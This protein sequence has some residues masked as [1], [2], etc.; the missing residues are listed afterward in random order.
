MTNY[1]KT[2][3]LLGALTALLFYIGSFW[4]QTGITMALVF[5]GLMNFV[6]YYYSDKIALSMYGAQPVSRADAPE[7]YRI[8]ENLTAR[9]NMPAPKIYIIPSESP[10]AFATGRNPQ[11]ASVAVTQGLMRILDGTELEGVIAHELGH[12]K[13]R[14]ILIA[15]I[16]ATIAAAVM[17][18]SS[19]A[20]WAAIFGGFGRD[21]ENGASGLEFLF[22][23]ILAPVAAMLIQLAVSR[24]REYGADS[25]G[26]YYAG[27]PYGLARALEKIHKYSQRVPLEA[28]PSTAHLFI[29]QPLVGGDFLK[30]LF[31]THPPIEK[32]IARLLGQAR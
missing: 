28:S 5:A 3:L 15:T 17:W 21:R 9:M 20:R 11:H 19:M 32:R 25:T 31:S 14:D 7:L 23:I 10:N 12:V 2:A 27:N 13:N 18:I 6:S 30:S 24:S 26:A 29:V 8:V 1:V 16:A 22:L 4:G